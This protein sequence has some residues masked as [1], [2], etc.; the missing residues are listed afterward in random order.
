MK[1]QGS[2]SANAISRRRFLQATAAL[3]VL[4]GWRG[5]APRPA[6]AANGPPQV[7]EVRDGEV[8]KLVIART[9]VV[10]GGREGSAITI[11]G[12]VPGP[13]LRFREGETVTLEVTNRL[14]EITSI[15]WHGVIVPQ[16]MDGVPGVSFPGIR[17]G[18]TFTYRYRLR[19]NGTYW[20]HSHLGLQE[21][22]GHYAPMIIDPAGT[23]PVA[24]DREHVVLLSDWTFE[25]PYRVLSKLKKQSDYYNFQQRTVGDFFRDVSRNGFRATLRERAMWGRMRMSPTDISDVTGYT[26]TYLV[27]GVAPEDNWT[28]PFQPGERVRLRFIN[29]AAST[30]F[31]VRIPG[32]PLTVVQA[33]GQNVQPVECDEFQIAVAET[34]DVI[35]EPG[36]DRA[37]TIFAEAMDRSGYGRATLAP[38]PGMSAAVPELRERPLRTMIDMGMDMGEMGMAGTEM[39]AGMPM[40]KGGAMPGMPA[41]TGQGAMPGME[42]GHAG[43]APGMAM[44]GMEAGKQ[45]TSGGAHAGMAMPGMEQAG[46]VVARH[47]PD[48]HGPANVSVATVQRN[49]LGERGTGLENVPHRVLVYTDLKSLEPNHDL[50]PPAREIELHLTG[51]METF[52]WG[53]D[54]KKFSE[55]DEP[56][57]LR[58]GER[59]RIVLVNDTMMEHPMHLHGMFKEIDTGADRAHRPRKH[60]ISVKAAER[61][62]FEL[63]A[64]EP[65]NWAF[66]CHLL[67]HLDMGMLRVVNVPLPEKEVHS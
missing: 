20:Y 25:N 15:H 14:E 11:N 67:Y 36:E 37:Y 4:A 41:G 2:Y 61:L 55:V 52:M 49:R 21:Q 23:D 58:Y 24:Y 50:R 46:P 39:G 13:L 28:A 26:Y 53:F 56:V 40:D 7:I 31:N 10:I 34:Y 45:A 32:L 44:P 64:D 29:A 18:Q 51:N 54:G 5:L 30:F 17:P 35:V 38:R 8:A 16:D 66:H 57:Y 27:N 43:H 1:E 22:A 62:A 19:Q 59:L 42:G 47:G 48:T 12:T 60:T 9:P 6:R 33:D 63:T 3:G 65:G